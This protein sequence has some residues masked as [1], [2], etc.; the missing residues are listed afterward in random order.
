MYLYV[1]YIMYIFRC[2]VTLQRMNLEESS[3]ID[4]LLSDYK[5]T[6]KTPV[7]PEAIHDGDSD[8]ERE[9]KSLSKL[10]V[11]LNKSKTGHRSA[12]KGMLK[13]ILNYLFID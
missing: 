2:E 7:K 4:N 11:L 6:K 12:N 13:R 10:Q 5:A 3:V 1:Y 9:I 8:L